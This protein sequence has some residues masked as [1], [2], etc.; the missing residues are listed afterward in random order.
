[1]EVP[2]SIRQESERVPQRTHATYTCIDTQAQTLSALQLIIP[3]N[4]VLPHASPPGILIVQHLDFTEIR[5][6]ATTEAN[7]ANSKTSAPAYP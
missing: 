1:M 4:T 6:E 7:T 2:Q 5:N 3:S